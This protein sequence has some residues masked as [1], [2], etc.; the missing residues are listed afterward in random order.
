MWL[1]VI[2]VAVTSILVLDVW[3]Y[4]SEKQKTLSHQ[5][6]EWTNKYPLLPF[7]VGMAVGVLAGHFWPVLGN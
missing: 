4:Y 2:I 7:F 3:A 5:V 1:M 6:V